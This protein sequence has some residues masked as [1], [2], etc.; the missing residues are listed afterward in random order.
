MPAWGGSQSRLPH[1]I[2]SIQIV[3]GECRSPPK[4]DRKQEAEPGKQE[5][6]G[7]QAAICEANLYNA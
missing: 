3:I 5:K 2:G 4:I 6:S 7:N 1:V